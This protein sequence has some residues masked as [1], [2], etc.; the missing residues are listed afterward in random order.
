MIDL[1]RGL[2]KE[3]SLHSRIVH[4]ISST[5]LKAIYSR[6]CGVENVI[7]PS[8]AAAVAYQFDEMPG[9]YSAQ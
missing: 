8:D 7:F 9:R 1:T 6:F 4:S 3:Q 5:Q 2:T